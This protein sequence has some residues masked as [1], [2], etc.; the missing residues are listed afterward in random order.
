MTS[1]GPIWTATG[2]KA[3]LLGLFFCVGSIACNGRLDLSGALPAADSGVEFVS[4]T[5]GGG[6]GAHGSGEICGN[7]F[8]DN[9]NAR[10]LSLIGSLMRNI[11]VGVVSD[12]DRLLSVNL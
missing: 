5:G 11:S 10:Y 9:D 4:T 8:D 2:I 7:G 1:V 12:A 6:A 3:G